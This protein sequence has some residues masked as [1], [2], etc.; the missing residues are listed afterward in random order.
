MSHYDEHYEEQAHEA[1]KAREEQKKNCAHQ[2]KP[3]RCDETGKTTELECSKCFK[4][5]ILG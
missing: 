2:W 1:R 3:Y 5:T 4:H